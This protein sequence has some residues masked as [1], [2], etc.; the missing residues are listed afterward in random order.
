MPRIYLDPPVENTQPTNRVYL[1]P[2]I[3]QPKQ[4]VYIDPPIKETVTPITMQ[5]NIPTPVAD[6]LSSMGNGIS[7]FF[8]LTPQDDSGVMVAPPMTGITTTTDMNTPPQ[9]E[10]PANSPRNF[11]PAT[12]T[13][14][15]L[16]AIKNF[17]PAFIQGAPTAL[18]ELGE[19]AANFAIKSA[20][21]LGKLSG[22]GPNAATMD[23]LAEVAKQALANNTEDMRRYW[24]GKQIERPIGAE[25]DVAKIGESKLTRQKVEE[26]IAKNPKLSDNAKEILRAKAQPETAMQSIEKTIANT[27]GAKGVIEDAAGLV[28]FAA[29]APADYYKIVR[30]ALAD[31][32]L[33]NANTSDAE[34]KKEILDN[35]MGVFGQVAAKTA[36]VY[37]IGKQINKARTTTVGQT[38]AEALQSKTVSEQGVQDVVKQSADFQAQNARNAEYYKNTVKPNNQYETQMGQRAAKEAKANVA[39]PDTSNYY[40]EIADNGLVKKDEIV[41]FYKG[42]GET[43]S[44][45]EAAKRRNL[46][47]PE[48]AQDMQK[49]TATQRNPQ[50]TSRAFEQ[51][52]ETPSQGTPQTVVE[53]PAIENIQAEVPNAPEAITTPLAVEAAK[54]P[55]PLPQIFAEKKAQ[56]LKGEELLKS[57]REE[58]AGQNKDLAEISSYDM[59]FDKKVTTEEALAQ[60]KEWQKKAE[61]RLLKTANDEL[62]NTSVDDFKTHDT[63]TASYTIGDIATEVEKALVQKYGG[64]E[65]TFYRPTERERNWYNEVDDVKK[66]PN[67]DIYKNKINE[68]EKN[69]L[70]KIWEIQDNPS[71][72]LKKET[73][74]KIQKIVESLKENTKMIETE[75]L[76]PAFSELGRNPIDERF[77][78]NFKE[79]GI[80]PS[81]SKIRGSVFSLNDELLK[82]VSDA[83]NVSYKAV[84]T[85]KSYMGEKFRNINLGNIGEILT[86]RDAQKMFGPVKDTPVFLISE[87]KIGKEGRYGGEVIQGPFGNHI[88]LY[89][90]HLKEMSLRRLKNTIAHEAQHLLQLKKGEV[91]DYGKPYEQRPME[92]EAKYIG[93]Q[94][95]TGKLS[96]FGGGQIQNAYNWLTSQKNTTPPPGNISNTEMYK[97]NLASES[98]VEKTTGQIGDILKKF[99]PGRMR[100]VQE[101]VQD[102]WG[103]IRNRVE[104]GVVDAETRL[105]EAQ[106]NPTASPALIKHLEKQYKKSVDEAVNLRKKIGDQDFIVSKLSAF[107]DEVRDVVGPLQEAGVNKT[108]LSTYMESKRLINEIENKPD[109]AMNIDPKH[110]ADAENFLDEVAKNPTFKAALDK[111]SAELG[112]IWNSTIV[113]GLRETGVIDDNLANLF[114][115]NQDYVPFKDLGHWFDQLA[116][117][118][119]AGTSSGPKPKKLVGSDFLRENVV[120]TF[121][122]RANQLIPWIE[123][124]KMK[125]YFVDFVDTFNQKYTR[126]LTP[127]EIKY[128]TSS[129]A[130]KNNVAE[131]VPTD[132]KGDIVTYKNGKEQAWTITDKDVKRVLKDP[133]GFQKWIYSMEAF[134]KFNDY[135]DPL[136]QTAAITLN[137]AFSMVGNPTMDILSAMQLTPGDAGKFTKNL[138]GGLASGAK[139][140]VGYSDALTRELKKE[141]AILPEGHTMQG[142]EERTMRSMATEELKKDFKK[143]FEYTPNGREILMDALKGV[144]GLFEVPLKAGELTT[145]LASAKGELEKMGVSNV[146]ELR[147]V[148]GEKAV[149][150]F[151]ETVRDTGSPRFSRSGRLAP[152]MKFF[153]KFLPAGIQGEFTDAHNLWNTMKNKPMRFLTFV[154]PTAAMILAQ[155]AAY[156][157]WLG[158]EERDK[159]V[160]AG[161]TDRTIKTSFLV[162]Q[163][164]G[165]FAKITKP[166][167]TYWLDAPFSGGDPDKMKQSMSDFMAGAIS[168]AAKNTV[169]SI[170]SASPWFQTGMLWSQFAKG[171]Q[172]IPENYAG[173]K[174][175]NKNQWNARNI[176]T[177]KGVL[178]ETWNQWGG[179]IFRMNPD[180]LRNITNA[181][182]E[183]TKGE[184][185]FLSP[186]RRKLVHLPT[187]NPSGLPTSNIRES[188]SQEDAT[189]A[190]QAQMLGAKFGVA[191]TPEEKKAILKEVANEVKQQPVE[192][193]KKFIEEFKY[194]TKKTNTGERVKD[195]TSF[196]K[197]IANTSKK[198][199][200]HLRAKLIK[201]YGFTDKEFV[202]MMREAYKK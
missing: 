169:N 152:V 16:E 143:F 37:G 161:V 18:G 176:E 155:R 17:A 140:A 85:M 109:V 80:D 57:V 190:N 23:Y 115:A 126:E 63:Q 134:K 92:I 118:Q 42:R 39:V 167:W 47:Y 4:R 10:P 59:A 64:N 124:Q 174:I 41:A 132:G 22:G 138:P 49:E 133:Y 31:A 181:E 86:G 70:R 100:V 149:S 201:D 13:D 81:L 125:N 120:D 87:A 15:N 27:P 56:G 151:V 5:E 46:A 180:N 173:Y 43:I 38:P 74:I 107:D 183:R 7:N 45:E 28:E 50:A 113:E 78:A 19:G 94:Y 73:A 137:T 89:L 139:A 104:Q 103:P 147:K 9:V 123:Q 65:D 60:Q 93:N 117:D 58:M 30:V 170:P 121:I 82:K 157:G 145:K 148:H 154:V 193:K 136:M 194:Q 84:K 141:G 128:G 202:E 88:N 171:G 179:S 163:G 68:T 129:E 8:T 146:A 192:Q 111:G 62:Q 1:D 95:R 21:D 200:P 112:N 98:A 11:V 55:K 72:P 164:N 32:G 14:I 71:Y 48:L 34:L 122:D 175:M 110:F 162:D 35:P 185:P 96:M 44:R 196:V 172:D 25:S 160:N 188:M 75:P 199:L 153:D 131:L 76:V 186:L 106:K 182:K 165:V 26:Y 197:L 91:N 20:Q 150:D 3:E 29:T 168:N 166:R 187:D 195:K 144:L 66:E 127:E 178:K 130:A 99:S 90:P 36:M 101:Y 114:K 77:E 40:T 53:P 135:V 2:P 177:L 142:R 198:E 51:L 105:S 6:A 116:G 33:I 79:R 108:A 24:E 159:Y 67:N 191:K 102:K 158:K 54:T 156:N 69:L 189:T 83:Y 52:P 97:R 12:Q 184:I 61:D 119:T